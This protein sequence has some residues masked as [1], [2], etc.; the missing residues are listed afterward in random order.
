ME[1]SS[2]VV[3]SEVFGHTLYGK[4]CTPTKKYGADRQADRQ[5]GQ[6]GP[7]PA[8]AQPAFPRG[9]RGESGRSTPSRPRLASGEMLSPMTKRKFWAGRSP[10]QRLA[11]T[12]SGEEPGKELGK[13]GKDLGGTAAAAPKTQTPQQR[14]TQIQILIASAAVR[15]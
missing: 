1:G 10:I 5:A 4:H 12:A 8:D 14:V 6:A 11:E 7:P 13:H 2:K 9:L 15:A 3:S